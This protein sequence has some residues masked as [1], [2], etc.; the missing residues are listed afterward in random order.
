ME[1]LQYCMD[2][3]PG[4]SLAII[5]NPRTQAFL[6]VLAAEHVPQSWMIGGYQEPDVRVIEFF[7]LVNFH[8]NDFFYSGRRM[9]VA[10]SHKWSNTYV[11][12]KL[13]FRRT[14]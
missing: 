8:E 9:G 7:L 14:K 6:E 1:S 10:R 13:G 5:P 3:A 12:Q 2:L 11:L 4:A